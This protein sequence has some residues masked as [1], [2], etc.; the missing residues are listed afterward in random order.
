[1]T[2]NESQPESAD[3][4]DSKALRKFRSWPVVILGVVVV[5]GIAW[6]GATVFQ[7]KTASTTAPKEEEKVDLP[8]L[9]QKADAGDQQ[10]IVKLASLYVLG[11]VVPPDLH[12]AASL[13]RRATDMGNAEATAALGELYQS[14]RL[15]P[16][17]LTTAVELYR[18]AAEMGNLTGQ[19]NLGY[20]Y[21][22]GQGVENDEK[23]ATTWYRLA[24]E[25]G[26]PAA[27]YDIAQR[28][29][30]GLG[31][32]VDLVEAYKW[33]KLATK[34][35]QPD[36]KKK[37]SALKDKLDSR[38]IKEGERRAAEFKPRPS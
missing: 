17:G 7:M 31:T 23:Q 18:K 19:Y 36:A 6:V 32:N 8:A 28:C 20:C 29:A 38:D 14:G 10:A 2:N 9:E 12:K 5:A 26:D 11:S 1:V 21:E 24:A 35:G 34:Q 4:P 27:Q 30:L 25:G 37:L 13:Y 33:Y 16:N 22:R 15:G 3:S